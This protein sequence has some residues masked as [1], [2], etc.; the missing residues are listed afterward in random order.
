MRNRWIRIKDY[1][2]PEDR[3]DLYALMGIVAKY[4]DPSEYDFTVTGAKI[5]IYPDDKTIDHILEEC[6]F[7]NL[8]IIHN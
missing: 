6:E 7:C 8:R 3:K 2:Y 1:S 5:E 4:L